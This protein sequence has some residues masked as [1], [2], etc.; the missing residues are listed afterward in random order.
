MKPMLMAIGLSCISAS[1]LAYVHSPKLEV[2]SINN[3][4]IVAMV[5]FD[6]P[7]L[8]DLYLAT[9]IHGV[10]HFMTPQSLFTPIVTVFV[11]NGSFDKD[12]PVLDIPSANI[13][14]ATYPLYQVVTLPGANP[15]DFNNWIGGINGLSKIEFKINLANTAPTPTPVVTTVPTTAPVVTTVPTTTPAVTTV[16]TTTPSVTA[17]PT[18]PPTVT[19]VPTV[20][21]TIAPTVAPTIAPTVAPTIAPTVAPTIAPTV[22]PTVA[23][24]TVPVLPGAALYKTALPGA[25]PGGSTC[26]SGGCH[27]ANPAAGKNKLL[28]SGKTLA[29]IKA[30]IANDANSGM[31]FLSTVADADLQLIAD[32]L[33]TQ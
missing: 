9:E 10:L 16:P 31:G 17:V 1:A 7:V 6:K 2:N 20:A 5:G 4:R 3:D 32:Y 26:S 19:T 11:K 8:G 18:T 25:S 28:P 27:G 30:G 12:L 33:A 13:E 22:A 21:P 14:P 15:L 23:P 29:G 24:T